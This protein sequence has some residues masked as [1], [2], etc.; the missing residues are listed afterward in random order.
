MEE[1]EEVKALLADE[2]M[3]RAKGGGDAEVAEKREDGFLKRWG[4]VRV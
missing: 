2:L 4:W 3:L 1:D